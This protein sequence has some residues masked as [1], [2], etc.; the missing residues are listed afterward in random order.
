MF[1]ERKV[2]QVAAYFLH[3]RGGQMSHLKLMKLLYLA[4]R[5]SMGVYGQPI[6]EDRMVSMPHGP[7]LSQ[8]YD[9]MLGS[10]PSSPEG[11]ESLIADIQD[12][13]VKLRR[14]VQPD[15]L[16]RLS[17]ADIDILDRIWDQFGH[18]TRWQIRDYT[19]DHCPEWED[20]KGSS[21]PLNPAKV[22]QALGRSPEEAKE[23]AADLQAKR[24]VDSV[25]A[26]L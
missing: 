24:R 3:K 1:D 25:F 9:L 26:S 5:E 7:V 12:H 18:M 11:W 4:D 16:G 10:T 15:E 2:A 6:S 20:P 14:P 17:D 19:H 21:K 8:T 23:L 22:F 13:Q